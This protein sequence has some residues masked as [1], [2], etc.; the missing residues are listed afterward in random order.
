MNEWINAKCIHTCKEVLAAWYL[1]I[2]AQACQ[3]KIG[4]NIAVKMILTVAFILSSLHNKHTKQDHST[5]RIQVSLK[6]FTFTSNIYCRCINIF[7]PVCWIRLFEL[8]T[9]NCIYT[10][11][12]TKTQ[13]IASAVLTQGNDNTQ[14]KWISK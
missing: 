9:V 6:I 3:R 14:I 5:T 1:D 2:V 8:M 13:N 4:H 7:V 10:A 12:L 11:D